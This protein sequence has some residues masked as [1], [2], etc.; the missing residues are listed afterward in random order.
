MIWQVLQIGESTFRRFNS[1]EL[2][3]GVYAG[4]RYKDGVKQIV[5]V[6]PEVAA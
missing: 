6:Q 5:V 2:L 1:P 4:A 3:P